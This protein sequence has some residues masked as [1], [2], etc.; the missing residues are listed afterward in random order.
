MPGFCYREEGDFRMSWRPALGDD[1]EVAAPRADD[2]GVWTDRRPG[3]NHARLAIVG[4]SRAAR[5]PIASADA[6][7]WIENRR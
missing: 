4:L 6:A 1:L 3:L 5:Q 2:E 7:I